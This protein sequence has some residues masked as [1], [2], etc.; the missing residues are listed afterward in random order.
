MSNHIYD[1]FSGWTLNDFATYLIAVFIC[2]LLLYFAFYIIMK[3]RS[4]ERIQL[5]PLCFIVL[6]GLSWGV[7][8]YFFLQ[9]KSDW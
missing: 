7:A 5:L 4:G 1:F 6:M 9:V 2:N 8:I 3:L